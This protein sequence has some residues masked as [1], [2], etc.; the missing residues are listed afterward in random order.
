LRDAHPELDIYHDTHFRFDYRR[1]DYVVGRSSDVLY[2]SKLNLFNVDVIFG[3]F[4]IGKYRQM[5]GPFVTFLRDP[6]ERIISAYSV[7]RTQPHVIDLNKDL[8]I[9]EYARITQNLM[10]NMLGESL[11]PYKFIGILEDYSM[12][13]ELMNMALSLNLTDQ[14]MDNVTEHK[15]PKYKPNVSERRR[16]AKYNR[17]DIDLYERSREKLYS[18]YQD[19]VAAA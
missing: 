13:I 3:H 10:V 8:G 16:V 4:T 15:Y 17:K 18:L 7:W 5:G 6:V 1:H 2:P 12:S 11:K 14:R 19:R 9:C